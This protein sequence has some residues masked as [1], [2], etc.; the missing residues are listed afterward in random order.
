MYGHARSNP[1]PRPQIIYGD[2]EYINECMKETVQDYR[3][4]AK[5]LRA[6]CDKPKIRLQILDIMHRLEN[7]LYHKTPEHR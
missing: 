2:R 6:T 1:N 5:A 3:F 4:Y 7:T